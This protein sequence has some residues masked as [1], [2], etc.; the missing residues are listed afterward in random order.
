MS[1]MKE[2]TTTSYA[3]L[4]WLAVKPWPTYELAKQMRRNLRFFWPRAESNLYAEPKNLIEHGLVRTKVT[5]SGKRARTTYSITPKGRK[6]LTAWLKQPSRDQ[7][8]E[9]EALVKIFF[10]A[11]GTKEDLLKTLENARY[12][13]DQI[14]GQGTIVANEY[15]SGR[16]QFPER[17][18]LSGIVFDFLW[19]YAELLKGWES[20]TR[21]EVNTWKDVTVIGK[22]E[23]AFQIFNDA[24]SLR[25]RAKK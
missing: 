8:L 16:Y 25:E 22:K 17:A 5:Y 3:I 15:L 13:A 6:A 23:R 2:L 11:Y 10:A 21:L 19:H 4:S 7:V 12:W 24:L 1:S 9:F 14:Q 20:R 18:H